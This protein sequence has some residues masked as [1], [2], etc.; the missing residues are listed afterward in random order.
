MSWKNLRLTECLGVAPAT[1]ERRPPAFQ[2]EME[3]VL[4]VFFMNSVGKPS[5]PSNGGG[6]PWACTV[7]QPVESSHI[8]TGAGALALLWA[9]WGPAATGPL[10]SGKPAA[11]QTLFLINGLWSRIGP[12]STSRIVGISEP[13]E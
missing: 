6:P 10:G 11:M 12:Y 8:G 2:V 4:F 1:E 3:K 9:P 13:S 7:R 5:A